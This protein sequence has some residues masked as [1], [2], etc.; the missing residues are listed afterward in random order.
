[1]FSES[2]RGLVLYNGVGNGGV[3]QRKGEELSSI[4]IFFIM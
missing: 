1:M 2:W 4:S 3:D